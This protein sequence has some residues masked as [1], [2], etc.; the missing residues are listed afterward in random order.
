MSS[1]AAGTFSLVR[2]PRFLTHPQVSLSLPLLPDPRRFPSASKRVCR[3]C[4][5]PGRGSCSCS[6]IDCPL[7]RRSARHACG[8]LASQNV[9]SGAR[10]SRRARSQGDRNRTQRPRARRS[11]IKCDF[12]A[13][14]SQPQLLGSGPSRCIQRRNHRGRFSALPAHCAHHT[15]A[16]RH[17]PAAICD[18]RR[19]RR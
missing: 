6:S 1:P 12:C 19:T 7:A 17:A 9:S 14:Q 15:A 3:W 18:F 2:L 16:H 4:R 11:P 8:R 10:Q 13:R 5:S